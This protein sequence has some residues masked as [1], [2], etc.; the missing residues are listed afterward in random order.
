MASNKHLIK[1]IM[2]LS[3]ALGL[4][5]DP[6]GLNN[7]KLAELASDLK[8]KKKDADNITLA[9]E[10][11]AKDEPEAKDTKKPEFYVMQ[12][13]CL[14]SKRGLL[15]DGDEIKV[16]DLSGGLVAIKAF[17]KSGHVGRG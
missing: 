17:V 3:L 16:E 5:V 6:E 11:E 14:T 2:A 7:A 9:D 12:G 13:K 8:A 15:S 10:S 1:E 4:E